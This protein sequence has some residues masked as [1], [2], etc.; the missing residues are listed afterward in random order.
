LIL[1]ISQAIQPNVG[2]DESAISAL[3]TAAEAY[4]LD[5]FTGEADSHPLIHQSK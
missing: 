4:I 1:S 5:F 2:W 3:Q